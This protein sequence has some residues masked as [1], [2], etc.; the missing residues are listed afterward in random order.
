M[1]ETFT[2]LRQV[3]T[4]WGILGTSASV[5][6]TKAIDDLEQDKYTPQRLFRDTIGLY[7]EA[8]KA[9]KRAEKTNKGP[10]PKDFKM[11]A[12]K[13]RSDPDK[14]FKA[15]VDAGTEL[16]TTGLTVCAGKPATPIDPSHITLD[17]PADG[18]FHVA[19]N[20]LNGLVVKGNTYHG[21]ISPKDGGPPLGM[22]FLKI[23]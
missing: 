12:P 10:A 16:E 23:T 3:A 6:F 22:L 9:W 17:V 1:S 14:T 11:S 4:F 7:D 15:S 20:K 5:R 19:F 21:P 8:F 2:Y 18:Q 13:G